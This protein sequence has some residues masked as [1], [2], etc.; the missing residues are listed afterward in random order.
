MRRKITT[1]IILV[2]TAPIWIPVWLFLLSN[3]HGMVESQKKIIAGD[4]KDRLEVVIVEEKSHL[5]IT[6]HN[7]TN[8][9][10][11]DDKTIAPFRAYTVEE[12]AELINLHPAALRRKLQESNRESDPFIQ[13]ANPQKIGKEWRF[14][15]ENILYALGSVSYTANPK[16]EPYEV[17][18]I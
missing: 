11:S 14:M 18:R 3:V 13:R 12:T 6:L 17:K 2:I 15:G 1:F 5:T 10:M 9:Y 8:S 7:V 16:T 4:E